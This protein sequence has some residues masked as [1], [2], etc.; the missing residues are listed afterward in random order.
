MNILPLALFDIGT[1]LHM[2]MTDAPLTYFINIKFQTG[3]L[4]CPC[5]FSVLLEHET[6]F[7]TYKLNIHKSLDPSWGVKEAEEIHFVLNV[8]RKKIAFPY[9]YL[10]FAHHIE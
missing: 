5:S 3:L 10:F 7:I 2:L 4:N 1:T 8:V 6:Y 9:N